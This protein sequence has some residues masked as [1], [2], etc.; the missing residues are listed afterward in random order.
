MAGYRVELPPDR[1]RAT[2]TEDHALIL[3]PEVVGPT[4]TRNQ[5]IIGEGHDLTG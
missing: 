4:I 3:T 2:F 1:L 5:G